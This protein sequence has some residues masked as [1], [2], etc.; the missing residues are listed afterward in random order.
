MNA[1]RWVARTLHITTSNTASAPTTSEAP[2]VSPSTTARPDFDCYTAYQFYNILRQKNIESWCQWHL[3]INGKDKAIKISKE[4]H[5]D[6]EKKSSKMK[7]EIH[8]IEKTFLKFMPSST[9][10]DQI[11]ELFKQASD[12]NCPLM[13]IKAYTKS[14]P[15]TEHI[16]NSSAANTYHAVKIYCTILNCSI[17]ARTQEYTDAITSIFFHRDLD[18]LLID[19][20][21]TV[22]RGYT[23]EDEKMLNSY[24]VGATILTTT[25]L[26]TSTNLEVA[27]RYAVNDGSDRTSVFCTYKVYKTYR[28]TALN[29]A[30]NSQHPDEDEILILRYVPFTI[31]FIEWTDNGRKMKIDFDE[32]R[33]S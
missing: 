15:F 11:R 7:N 28:R 14:Q 17:L 23:V 27:M 32:C 25:Q 9:E 30:L 31:T 1:L 33:D 12:R 6:F 20:D 8:I 19:R 26:S 13:F 16:N 10:W 5:Q 3:V 22:Y 18:K 24:E 21:R 4:F 29:I 2:L